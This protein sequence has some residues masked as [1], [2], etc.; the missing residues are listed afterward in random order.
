MTC[1]HCGK[2]KFDGNTCLSC[3]APANTTETKQEET[4]RMG[5][6]YFRGYMLYIEHDNSRDVANY[7]FYLGPDLIDK[8]TIPRDMWRN[9]AAELASAVSSDEFLWELFLLSQGENKEWAVEM[10]RKN[11]RVKAKMFTITCKEP[12]EPYRE[13]GFNMKD[14]RMVKQ[15][16]GL[17]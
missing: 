15:K 6:Q 9:L 17:A 16:L 4:F 12:E 14:L 2:D 1:N 7:Y 5:P 11:S 13:Y 10:S 8:I 3:G